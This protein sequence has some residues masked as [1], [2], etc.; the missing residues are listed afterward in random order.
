MRGEGGV[1]VKGELFVYQSFIPGVSAGDKIT[2]RHWT[3]S[4][5]L[6]HLSEQKSICSAKLS[7]QRMRTHMN[8]TA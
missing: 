7:K 1:L 4:E 8:A 5:H 3:F 6:R 2:V